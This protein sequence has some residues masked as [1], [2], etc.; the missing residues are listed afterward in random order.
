MVLPISIS[1]SSHALFAACSE[2]NP[3]LLDA[4]IYVGYSAGGGLSRPRTGVART[5]TIFYRLLRKD[6][7]GALRHVLYR[8]VRMDKDE[9]RGLEGETT[10]KRHGRCTPMGARRRTTLLGC[11]ASTYFRSGLQRISCRIR[12]EASAS[13][14]AQMMVSL[15][16]SLGS[17]SSAPLEYHAHDGPSSYVRSHPIQ[18]SR[19][20]RF[21]T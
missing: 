9:L 10:L 19:L 13:Y 8:V 3:H 12:L 18:D 6:G 14:P 20:S 15:L 17:R 21:I 11:Q 5:V 7:F 16:L 4:G 1:L 2:P